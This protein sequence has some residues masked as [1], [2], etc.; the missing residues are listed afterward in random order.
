M[1]EKTRLFIENHLQDDIHQLVLQAQRY[2]DIDMTLAI[3]QIKGR[4]KMQ[5]KVPA[6]YKCKEI[7][8]PAGLSLEQSSSEITAGYKAALCRGNTFTDLTG[9]F[10]VDC[11]FLAKNFRKAAYVE[12]QKELCDIATHNFNVLNAHNIQIINE[13]AEDYLNKTEAVDCIYID[14]ARRNKNGK[15]LVLLSHCEP[16]ITCLAPQLLEKAQKVMIKLS[17]M[18]DVS[19]AINDLPAIAEIHIVAV[20]NECKEILLLLQ[21]EQTENINISTINFLKNGKKEVFQY[22]YHLEK[23]SSIAYTAE[24]KKYLYEP[25]AAIMKSGAFKLTAQHYQLEKLHPNTH[26]YTS[27]NYRE[28]FPGH[29]FEVKE[30]WENSNKILKKHTE[31]LKQA[32]I[33]TRNFPTGTDE[34]RKKIKTF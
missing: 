14:P 4:R 17:P 29:V 32:N 5:Y 6:F 30:V 1:D 21:K 2:P 8:Y 9:G 26:L 20:E 24:V 18:L 13:S 12:K 11:Y 27:D 16:D 15:K 28:E 34:L 7:L 19:S 23:E 22:D 33:T 31:K 3:R 10:G 25:N